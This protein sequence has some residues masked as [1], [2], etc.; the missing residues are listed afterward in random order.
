[1]LTGARLSGEQALALGVVDSVA[2]KEALVGM[3]LELCD[4]MR[5]KSRQLLAGLKYGQNKALV[6][7]ILSDTADDPITAHSYWPL[8]AQ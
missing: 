5:G 3:G 2:S 1:M 7:L 4:P 8:A 6:D